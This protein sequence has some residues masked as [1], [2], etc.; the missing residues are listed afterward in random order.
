MNAIGIQ[1]RRILLVED[2]L[3]IADLIRVGLGKRNATMD[4]AATIADARRILG[5][6]RSYDA[7]L[8]D[9]TLPDGD[10]A[11]LAEVCRQSGRDIP[12]LMV[13]AQSDVADRIAGL[14]RGADDYIC[15][16]FSIDEL[17]ARLEAV[18]RRFVSRVKH[19]MKYDDLELDLI[20][21]TI[22][23]A[24]LEKSLSARETD[25][26]A[27]LMSHPDE[28]LTKDRI[29]EDVWGDEAIGDANVLHVYANYLRNRTED[30]RFP[31][32]IHTIR[33]VGYVLSRFPP[34]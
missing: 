25:L 32:L 5:T 15:K 23:R 28:V 14:A 8:L 1:G 29:L 7:L 12:I 19:V 4:H 9:L 16:P 17:I 21:R 30:G 24:D 31:R 20:R 3:S 6:H 10:G 34:D 22:R 11:T 26:L 27:Y 18:M 13:S 2:D 33:G